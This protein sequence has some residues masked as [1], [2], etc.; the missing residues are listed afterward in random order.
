[1]KYAGGFKDLQ[2]DGEGV[3]GSFKLPQPAPQKMVYE[4]YPT[5]LCMSIALH[6]SSHSHQVQ[7]RHA[8][9]REVRISHFRLRIG[10]SQ[11]Q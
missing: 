4:E 10:R 6:L 1:M 11:P 2:G 5:H 7:S 9:A 3:P 8:L